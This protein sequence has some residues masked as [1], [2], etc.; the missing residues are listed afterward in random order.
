MMKKN[1]IRKLF[2][3]MKANGYRTRVNYPE[4]I[5]WREATA[6][7]VAQGYRQ[8]LR[9]RRARKKHNQYLRCQQAK[10]TNDE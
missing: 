6:E 4:S 8:Y 2:S 10:K 3:W 1:K 7:E 5:F 9:S